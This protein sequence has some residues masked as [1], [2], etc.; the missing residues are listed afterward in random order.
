[1]MVRLL[2]LVS[3]FSLAAVTAVSA[4]TV[5][6]RQ[7][8][9][10]AA[11]P[12]SVELGSVLDLEVV[13]DSEGEDITGYVFYIAFE[14]GDF[15]P[16]LRTGDK[17]RQEPFLARDFLE[18]ISLIN[19]V[20]SVGGE[21]FLTFGLAG[22]P[23]GGDQR[24]SVNGLGVAA[25]FSLE[26]LR[27]PV[28]DVVTVRIEE[29]GHDRVSTY[30]TAAE[31][32][33]EKRFAP[34]LGEAQVRVTGFRILPLPDL[35]LI[36]GEATAVL[37]LNDFV[38]Q[39]GADV[40]WSHSLLSEIPTE[41]DPETGLVTMTP[42]SGFTTATGGNT[43]MTFT[44]LEV[45]EGLTAADTVSITVISPPRISDFPPQ[46]LFNEDSFNANLDLDAFVK[47]LDD[48]DHQLT[49]SQLGVSKNVQTNVAQGGVITFTAAADWFGQEMVELEVVDR[50]SLADTV[51]TTVVVAPVNDP[52]TA[53]RPA[54]V[55]PVKGGDPVVVPLSALLSDIDDEIADLGLELSD[56]F[57]IST[58]IQDDDLLITGL[59]VGRSVID[60][61]VRD[62]AGATASSRMV[63]VVLAENGMIVPAVDAIPPVRLLGGQSGRVELGDYVDDDTPDQL[64]W[65]ATADSGLDVALEGSLLSVSGAGV[66]IGSSSVALQVVDPDGNE[67]GGSVEVQILG[68]ED[69]RAPVIS[70]PPMIGLAADLP[71]DLA[72]DDLVDD[73]DHSDSEI[74]WTFEA[75]AGITVEPNE[76][77]RRL[78]L[79]GSAGSSSPSMLRL[80]AEDPVGLRDTVDV[81]LLVGSPNQGPELRP[82][83]NQTLES[84][85][86]VVQLD[87]DD[88]AFDADDAEAELAWTVQPLAG[89]V[90]ELDPVSHVLT[91]RRVESEGEPATETQLAL[92]VSDTDGNV[93]SGLM[94]ILLPPI[95]ELAAIPDVEFF[96]GE[97]D[98]SLVLDDHVIGLA[99]SLTW[100]ALPSQGFDVV[101]DTVDT[102]THRVR[103][104]P[105]ASTF[106]G[107]ETLRFTATDST[108]R[109]RTA[110]VLVR[111]KGRGL[112]PQ[113]SALPRI[114]LLEGESNSDLDLDDFVID[115]DPAA[116]H[117]WSFSGQRTV[118]VSVDAE[119][120]VLTLDAAKIEPGLEEIQFL[121][122]DPAGNVGLAV[123]E[124]LLLRGGAAPFI[125]PLPQLVMEAGS[126][127]EQLGLDVFVRDEDTPDADIVWQV[128]APVGVGAW[129]EERRLFI[130]VPAGATGTRNILL[131]ARDP[132]G[133]VAEGTIQIA[134]REDT[135]PP[136]V[137]LAVRR[138]SVFEELLELVLVAEEELGAPPVLVADGDTLQVVDRGGNRYQATYQFPLQ[139]GEH[140]IDVTAA[141]VDDVGN[142]TTV[143]KTITLSWVRERGGSVSSEDLQMRLNVPSGGDGFGQLA[144]L[145]RVD[146]EQVPPGNEGEAAYLVDLVGTDKLEEPATIIFFVDRPVEP[147]LGILRW[148]EQHQVWEELPTRVDEDSGWLS[149]PVRDLG[150]FRVGTVSP[151]RRLGRHK[152]SN[153][154]NPFSPATTGVTQ[155][156]YELTSPG[157]IQL[158]LYNSVGQRVR[159]LVDEFRDVGVW[160]ALW[161]G[162]D[163]NGRR[164]ASGIYVYEL[165]AGGTRHRGTLML[166]R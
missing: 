63:A 75:P 156:V 3:A 51:A 84:A 124:V 15:L 60:F 49:W 58:R 10:A 139:E 4:A 136:G 62:M 26:V 54:A 85:E 87:L 45:R 97:S 39:D 115:D 37:Q 65:T 142:E 116:D 149:S 117:V 89:V 112:T 138:H 68:P 106:Q 47:D 96:V 59:Q 42:Q 153:Y 36:E 34:P 72:L 31:P 19:E 94:R 140:F 160:S 125:S 64:T 17:G 73:P 129:I 86:D 5:E 98:T 118:A 101:I 20:E 151:D 161:D 24:Q 16:L 152:L 108:G 43:R 111:V 90:V 109:S 2:Q 141:A 79:V 105:V 22:W 158:A 6:L 126:A 123:L 122:R 29:R 61:T 159:V 145:Q 46:I 154:P 23:G 128:E 81:E 155:I 132:Q 55:Y 148:D 165:S 95:F 82:F 13:V 1:M 121:V 143:E 52:P 30:L 53:V 9:A 162:I 27:R 131:R 147:D 130:T 74:Q 25:T 119:S 67:A 127:E 57:G 8:G 134:I 12:I 107:T 91:V 110:F 100:E 103:M 77:N 144:L 164:L 40:I 83:L 48:P 44:A 137:E 70:P 93:E 32:G 104:A 71:V 41:I 11:E 66:F 146:E 18:G 114:E 99:S 38:K 157:P 7:Q 33:T 120:H 21:V 135:L 50:T 113:V 88:F 150:I 69:D 163:A 56:P 28:G 133:N 76:E 80:I 92:F 35:V 102:S 78:R 14:A 166:L